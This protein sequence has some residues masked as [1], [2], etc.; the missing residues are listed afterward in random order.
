MGEF[1]DVLIGP[2]ILQGFWLF[3]CYPLSKPHQTTSDGVP[4]LCFRN[5]TAHGFSAFLSV[6]C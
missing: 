4:G 2:V 5:F 6:D 3:N 1:F